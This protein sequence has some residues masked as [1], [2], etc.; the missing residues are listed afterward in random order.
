MD[1]NIKVEFTE[2]PTQVPRPTLG[3]DESMKQT[4]TPTQVPTPNLGPDKEQPPP[5]PPEKG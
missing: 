4:E 3:P 2:T 5:P 1:D